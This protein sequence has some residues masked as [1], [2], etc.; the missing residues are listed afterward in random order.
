MKEA[1]LGVL[2]GNVVQHS[3]LST[4]NNTKNISQNCRLAEPDFNLMH[5]CQKGTC[6]VVWLYA[7]GITRNRRIN[8]GLKHTNSQKTTRRANCGGGGDRRLKI[9]ARFTHRMCY[10]NVH[11]IP[12]LVPLLNKINPIHMLP[13]CLFQN[14]F[15]I[16]LFSNLPNGYHA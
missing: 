14:S 1:V 9:S 16:P 3:P 4:E 10:Q 13:S 11:N 12:P 5:P 2:W 8:F 7:H 15:N 6:V